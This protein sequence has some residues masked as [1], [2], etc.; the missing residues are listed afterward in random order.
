M[1]GDIQDH[2]VYILGA[3]FSRDAGAPLIH[4]FLDRA[5]EFFDDPD[6]ALDPQERQQFEQVFKFKREVAKAREKFRIDLDNIEQLFGLVEMSQRLGSVG[7]DTRDAMVYLI[8]KTLQ[9]TLANTS[10]RSEVK[11]NLA[12]GY[13]SQASFVNYVRRSSSGVDSIDTDIYTHFALY[14]SGKYDDQ[15]N[16]SSRSST[17][18]TFN[19]DLILDDALAGVEANP[20]YEL[21]G[22]V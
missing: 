18:I 16:L 14:L 22:A 7:S 21:G 1:T 20:G 6:S 4:D 15:R 5:R 9:L 17:V 12:L 19:Y 13:A 3:G 10:R 2:N 11:M 8:A